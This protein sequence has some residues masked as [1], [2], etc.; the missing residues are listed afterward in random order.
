MDHCTRLLPLLFL[1]W[2]RLTEHL[3]ISNHN[4][5]VTLVISLNFG[6]GIELLS[7]DPIFT[8]PTLLSP[9]H[10]FYVMYGLTSFSLMHTKAIFYMEQSRILF[11]GGCWESSTTQFS[12]AYGKFGKYH[13]MEITIANCYCINFKNQCLKYN[14]HTEN[15]DILWIWL[16]QHCPLLNTAVKLTA[17][18]QEH[19]FTISQ[20]LL[21][22]LSK[23][24]H[25]TVSDTIGTLCQYF[26]FINGTITH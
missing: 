8:S 17:H 5:P 26:N 25:I 14:N 7:P 20:V 23:V 13:F 12:T 6:S 4:C 19:T 15:K 11:F 22:T 16:P 3:G 21:P 1:S 24:T 9:K 18:C 2:I 10:G